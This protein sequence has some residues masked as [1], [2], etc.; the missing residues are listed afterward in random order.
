MNASIRPA[1]AIFKTRTL[2]GVWFRFFLEVF[3]YA[4]P[5]CQLISR[6]IYKKKLFLVEAIIHIFYYIYYNLTISDRRP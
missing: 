3:F 2:L 4:N 6:T 1:L 5:T